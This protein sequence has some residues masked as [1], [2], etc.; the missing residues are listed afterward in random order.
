MTGVQTCALPIY[1][2]ARWDGSVWSSL[3]TGSGNGVN[4][5]VRALAVSGSDL[6]VGGFFTQAGGVPANLVARWNGSTWSSLGTGIIG[7]GVNFS[8][9]YDL[10]VSGSDL[11]VGGIFTQAGG[12]PANNVARWNGSAWSSLGT[13]SGNGVNFLV[14]ALAISGSDL[15]VGGLFAQAGGLPANRVA[16]WNGS[17]WSSLGT[18]SGNGVDNTVNALAVSG[19]DLYV[20]GSFR[21]AGGQVSSSIA[22]WTPDDLFRNGF[23]GN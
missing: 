20:G 4:N 16:R 11:Y 13:G 1:G 6:Y 10:A 17:A 2:V 14:F 12:L 7:N 22:K 18:D 3:G 15:Y 9:V 5:H 23:E 8:T 19:S 21:T